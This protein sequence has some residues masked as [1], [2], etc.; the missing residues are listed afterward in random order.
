MSNFS[1]LQQELMMLWSSRIKEIEGL[2]ETGRKFRV[3]RPINYVRD[4]SQ[5]NY[6]ALMVDMKKQLR[7][8]RKQ[9]AELQREMKDVLKMM[10]SKKN[11]T[12]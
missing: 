1:E 2:K 11:L 9:M 3:T 10:D 12:C 7:L 5:K 4:N 6:K 8:M